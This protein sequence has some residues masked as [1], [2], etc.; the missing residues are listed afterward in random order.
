MEAG[1]VIIGA[2]ATA[3]GDEADAAQIQESTTSQLDVLGLN[4]QAQTSSD[5]M[6]SLFGSGEFAGNIGNYYDP[7]NSLLPAVLTHRRGNPITLSVL[8]MAVGR[9]VGLTLK[10]VSMPGHFLLA[11]DDAR[12]VWLDPF[13]SGAVLHEEELRAFFARLHGDT[14]QL[15]P[16][17]LVPVPAASVL[18]RMLNNLR[19][20]YS[21]HDSLD[22]LA[23]VGRLSAALPGGGA[24]WAM[25]VAHLLE[26][27]RRHEDAAKIFDVAAEYGPEPL[28]ATYATEAIRLRNFA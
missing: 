6:L 12:G 9:R 24:Q 20:I 27:K 10:G 23:W 28:R 14:A 18:G 25:P 1:A 2:L 21:H 17:H 16:Q 26:Q 13:H 8:A 15:Q 3:N 5:L 11:A 22:D 19:I 7:A 4:H